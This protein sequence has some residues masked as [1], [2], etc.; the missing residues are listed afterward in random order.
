MDKKHLKIVVVALGAVLC[1]IAF[2][3]F[4]APFVT[5]KA[6]S[7]TRNIS[8]FQIAFDFESLTGKGEYVTENGSIFGTFISFA[9]TLGAFV[10]S[11]V[12]LVIAVLTLLGKFTP[13]N[14][15]DPAKQKNAFVVTLIMNVFLGAIPMILNFCTVGM[16]GYSDNPLASLGAGAIASG[17]LLFIGQVVI[18]FANFIK[19]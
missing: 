9:M 12:G 4:A 2:F 10:G 11:L 3:L 14:A 1:T 8:G 15:G 17:I 19:E 13:K 6:G 18:I 16:A 7:L 5:L